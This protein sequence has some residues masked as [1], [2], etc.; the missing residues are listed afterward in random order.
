MKELL[1]AITLLT[2]SCAQQKVVLKEQNLI[3]YEDFSKVT[4]LNEATM[5]IKLSALVDQRNVAEVG[6]ARTGAQFKKTPVEFKYNFSEYFKDYLRN[7]LSRRNVLM[8]MTDEKAVMS[9][10]VKEFWTKEVLERFK[11]ERASC[12]IAIDVKVVKEDDSYSGSF[13]TEVKSPGDM[14]D[15]TEKLAPTIASC[16]NI[17]VEKIVNDKN[18]LE[19]IKS[20]PLI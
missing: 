14:G 6:Q 20:K 18:L 8:V 4:I 15:A 13:W 11:P 3:P 7:S 5:P 17:I 10:V 12:K 9:I 19:F 1:F 2:I 16:M